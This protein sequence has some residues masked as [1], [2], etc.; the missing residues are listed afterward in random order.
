M[1][2]IVS[3]A[4]FFISVFG[5]S[6]TP[7]KI[8]YQAVARDASGNIVTSAI[9][10]KFQILQGSMSG[11]VVYEETHTATPGLSGVFNVPIGG[12]TVVLGN[13]NTIAW[14]LNTYYLKVNIDPS[15]G[16]SYTTVGTSQF[17]SVPYALFAEKT[18]P[19]VLNVTPSGSVNILAVGP[20]TVAI[21]AGGAVTSPTLIG[22]PPITVTPSPAIGTPTAYIISTSTSTGVTTTSLQINAPNAIT[23]LGPNNYSISIAPTNLTSTGAAS[24]TGTYPN[25][26]I[27]VPAP[28]LSVT[29]N[30]IS[31]T[32]GSAVSTQ[33]ISSGPWIQSVGSVS[34]TNANDNVSIGTT[35][36]TS[37]LNIAT[38][39]GFG[40]N[41]ISV[42][43]QSSVDALQVFKFAGT[44]AGLRLINASATNTSVATITSSGGGSPI[45]VDINISSN[46]PALMAQTTGTG[47]AVLAINQSSGPSVKGTKT[48]SVGNAGLFDINSTASAADALVAS[49]IGNGAAI[50]AISGAANTSSVALWLENGHLKSTSAAP[51]VV[52][53]ATN[54]LGGFSSTATITPNSTDMKGVVT[55]TTNATGVAPGNYTD[56]NVSFNKPYSVGPTVVVSQ[57]DAGRFSYAV[58]NMT[59]TFFTV[60]IYNNTNVSLPAVSNFFRFSY[61]VIE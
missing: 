53:I 19:P 34:L 60:R 24:V 12:G 51:P 31:L 27:Y 45:G 10:I 54:S 32:T 37:K 4:L 25:Y 41:D 52:T 29:G 57:Y 30:T 21:P 50:H 18:P 26:N 5:F 9:G 36:N 46:N 11:T 35:A 42:S 20:S 14:G 15:G 47:A 16:T 1:N 2:K 6:Q 3:I 43:S 8:N 58:L 33:T 13:F 7:Q 38:P 44:G 56:V 17:I 49:T 48:T 39:A 28:M 61:M 22:T 23:T 59:N 55:V 40:S